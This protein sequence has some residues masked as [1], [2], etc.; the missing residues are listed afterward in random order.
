M[1]RF[2]PIIAF[3]FFKTSLIST[4]PTSSPLLNSHQERAD[5]CGLFDADSGCLSSADNSYFIATADVEGGIPSDETASDN[6]Y[7]FFGSSRQISFMDDLSMPTLDSNSIAAENLNSDF[8]QS[9]LDGTALKTDSNV[10]LDDVLEEP[11]PEQAETMFMYGSD[12]AHIGEISQSTK[13]LPVIYSYICEEHADPCAQFKDG[14][15]TG[16]TRYAKCNNID[17]HCRLC[18]IYG[19]ECDPD[20]GWNKQAI[21]SPENQWGQ[22]WNHCRNRKCGPCE[23]AARMLGFLSLGVI[24]GCGPSRF[25]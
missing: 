18:D 7:D 11:I 12:D 25:D 20:S 22:P 15:A 10:F 13:P 14:V 2:H 24:P 1:V 9:Q 4:F 17:Q 8:G 5:S 16:V 3:I 23:T 21:P 19:R 6:D